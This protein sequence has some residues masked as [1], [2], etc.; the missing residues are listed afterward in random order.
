MALLTELNNAGTTM[1][2]ITHEQAVADACQRQ[3]LMRDGQLIS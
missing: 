3:V 2:I 1:V